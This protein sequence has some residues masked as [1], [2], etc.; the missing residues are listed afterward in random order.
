MTSRRGICTIIAPC[1]AR[2]MPSSS[3]TTTSPSARCSSRCSSSAG[4]RPCTS[5]SAEE[6]VRALDARPYDVVL[7]DV[8]M[9][10]MDG[11]ALLD[12]VG[13]RF[14]GLPVILL[15]AHGSV[16]LAV[17]AMKRGAA[18]FVQKP[19]DKDEIG[20]VIE[21]A[22]A[23]SRRARADV[24][25]PPPARPQLR[26]ASRAPMQAG[27][28]HDPQG[29]A[30][31]QPRCSSAARRAPARSSSRARCTRRARARSEAFVSVHC[32]ALP[33]SLLESELFG[34]EKGA[35]TGAAQRKP[36]RIEL[37]HKGTLFLDEIGDVPRSVQ[38]KLL[39]VIQ[40]RELRARRRHA[41]HSRRRAHH[42]GDAPRSR[43]DGRGRRVPRRPLLS[44]RR[45]ADP[46]P[47]AA[48]A[49]AT[50]RRGSRVT[51]SSDCA[52]SARTRSH[53]HRRR[54][55]RAARGAAVA[56]A[57]CGSSRTSSSGSSCSPTAT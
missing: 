27:V 9:P 38:V 56:R 45:R 44:A 29:R 35:F 53:A 41:D 14:P 39:R 55:R 18:D 57:T 32:A 52:K 4:S 16:A 46:H 34:H 15:T 1:R 22:L 6:A 36:G 7:S 51:S 20:F 28:R 47:A 49:R 33:E 21:K 37:A 5:P 8:R 48:R 10:G 2:P 3:S 24:P 25:P 19:F 26:R 31:E 43:G 50:T 42:R 17:E 12:H 13:A 54:R 30:H 11:M 40:E 23:S